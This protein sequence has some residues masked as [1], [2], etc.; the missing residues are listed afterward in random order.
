MGRRFDSDRWLHAISKE[1]FWRRS[2]S[3]G[4]LSR[5]GGDRWLQNL[6][7][8]GF[9]LRSQRLEIDCECAQ[10]GRELDFLLCLGYFGFYFKKTMIKTLEEI[11]QL[12]LPADA[13]ERVER[14]QKLTD[15]EIK[16]RRETRGYR[17]NDEAANERVL[18]DKDLDRIIEWHRAFGRMDIEGVHYGEQ[19]REQI[20]GRVFG[21][22]RAEIEGI[23][24]RMLDEVIEGMNERMRAVNLTVDRVRLEIADRAGLVILGKRG[25]GLWLPKIADVRGRLRQ[26][27]AAW[28]APA[29]VP[30]APVAAPVTLSRREETEAAKLLRIAR[31]VRIDEK[32]IHVFIF[33]KSGD[34]PLSAEQLHQRI[35]VNIEI[36]TEAVRQALANEVFKKFVEECGYSLRME[37]ATYQLVRKESSF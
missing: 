7:V 27:V 29:I 16:V 21:V 34:Q 37:G 10:S 12:E 13:G 8:N 30:A 20:L 36:E 32:W 17:G 24:Q 4:A 26:E 19:L 11:F 2:E 33:L 14:L 9:S 5:G 35:S 3:D 1:P 6:P 25:G 23:D 15:A 31:L 18:I 22:E 28:F